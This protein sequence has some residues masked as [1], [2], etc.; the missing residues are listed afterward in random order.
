VT[1]TLPGVPAGTVARG[2]QL[3]SAARQAIGEPEATDEEI[4]DH[5]TLGR[6]CGAAAP[7]APVDVGA[8]WV[9]ADLG[10]EGDAEA[11]E[12]LL[13][14]LG[15]GP[16]DPDEVARRAQEWRLPVTPYRASP[17][18]ARCPGLPV[19][20]R[21]RPL[22]GTRVVDLTSMWAGPLAT[23]LLATAGAEVDTVEAAC[24][25]DGLRGTPAMFEALAAGK[26]RHDLDLRQD[27]ARRAFLDLVADADVVVESYSPRVLPNL[28]LDLPTLLAVNPDV[29]LVS[30]P[31]FGPASPERD[32][33]AYGTGVHAA[34]GLG[35]EDDGRAWAPA[36][37]YPDPLGGLAAFAAVCTALAMGL[38]G[39]HLAV[40]LEA[41]LGGL[42]R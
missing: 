31:A 7:S 34:S 11:F 19:V 25:P 39:R 41:A 12:R 23:H 4:V 28:G 5:L 20:D 24:R 13:N 30:I 17:R 36:V 32:W 9:C 37:T 40:P 38:R 33:V 26:R 21:S 29:V 27:E 3:L 35:I 10:G 16:H 22:A 42:G 1:S 8:G 6:R 14:V 2:R 15:S 18:R